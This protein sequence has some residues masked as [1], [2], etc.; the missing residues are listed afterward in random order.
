MTASRRRRP[1][2]SIT[3]FKLNLSNETLF[4]PQSI[5]PRFPDDTQSV[6]IDGDDQD[7]PDD[8]LLDKRGDSHDI[9]AKAN[10]GHGECAD[11]CAADITASSHETCAANYDGGNR[12]QFVSEA[13]TRMCRIDAGGEYNGGN[14]DEAAAKTV[15]EHLEASYW[16]A[17]ASGGFFTAADSVGV[18]S[19]LSLV[20]N[21]RSDKRHCSQ[22]DD[23]YRNPIDLAASD[24]IEIFGK[25]VHREPTAERQR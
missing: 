19:Q 3:I 18:P 23:W 24:K 13:D 16:Y 7:Y 1:I 14:S 8:N 15:D 21:E 12:V 4:S 2:A 25:S 10:R 9:E 17:G 11:N 22:D 20:K 5:E 6:E